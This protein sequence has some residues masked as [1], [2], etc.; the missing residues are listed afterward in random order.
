VTVNQLNVGASSADF[1]SIRSVREHIVAFM[2]SWNRNLTPRTWTK[3][4][5]AIIRSHRRMLDRISP[6]VHHPHVCWQQMQVG[7][8]AEGV[9]RQVRAELLPDD[10]GVGCLHRV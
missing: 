6:V 10:S 5:V 1:S 7:A 8:P 4:A 3:P 2:R 9:P